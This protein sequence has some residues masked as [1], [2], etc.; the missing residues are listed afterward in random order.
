LPFTLARGYLIHRTVAGSLIL[1]GLT[2]AAAGMR[3]FFRTA[4]PA[5]TNEPPAR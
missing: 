4:T 1:I 2:L 5:P 3:N